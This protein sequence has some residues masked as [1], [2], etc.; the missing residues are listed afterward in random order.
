LPNVKKDEDKLIFANI[1]IDYSEF[2]YDEFIDNADLTYKDATI[3]GIKKGY[4]DRYFYKTLGD[5]NHLKDNAVLVVGSKTWPN[6]ENAFNVR[7][8]FEYLKLEKQKRQISEEEQ[9]VIARIEAMIK[10]T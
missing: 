8:Y 4:L 1:V 7:K 5:A 6:K 9:K 3:S 2:M 10:K